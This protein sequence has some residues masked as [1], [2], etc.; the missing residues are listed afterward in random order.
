MAVLDS[1]H[2]QKFKLQILKP[3]VNAV[4][5]Q[6]RGDIIMAALKDAADAGA[7]V[8]VAVVS[9]ASRSLSWNGWPFTGYEQAAS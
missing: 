4:S 3:L 5:S 6:A 8:L 2:A 7:V 1:L 9:G